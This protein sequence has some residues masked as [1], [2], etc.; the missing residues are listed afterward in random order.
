MTGKDRA[1]NRLLIKCPQILYTAASASDNQRINLICCVKVFNRF[2]NAFRRTDT[3]YLCSCLN[4]FS[5]WQS[6]DPAKE[7]AE[8]LTILELD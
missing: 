6:S 5:E 3:L 1:G 4:Y 8:A 7:V 2:N